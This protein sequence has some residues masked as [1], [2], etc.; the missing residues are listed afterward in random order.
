MPLFTFV[1]ADEHETEVLCRH[2]E[3][4]TATEPCETCGL[5][6]KWRGV[7][8]VQT[9]DFAKGKYGMQAI[10][11]DGSKRRVNNAASDRKRSDY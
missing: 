11:G 10:M 5:E 3:V 8:L 4:H 1:C 7:E 9:R 2:D 6:A